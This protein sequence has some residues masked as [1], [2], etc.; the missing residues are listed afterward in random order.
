MPR[1]DDMLAQVKDGQ[2]GHWR[3]RLA[4]AEELMEAFQTG[5]IVECVPPV[6]D[7]LLAFVG[8][9]KWEVRK[10]VA[11][12][13]SL[14][15]GDLFDELAAKL[16]ADSNGFVRGAAERSYALRREHRR[17]AR[18]Q[19]SAEKGLAGR[20]AALRQKYGNDVVNDIFEISDARFNLMAGS[21]AHDMRSIFT[22]L[23]PAAKAML[24]AIDEDTDRTVLKRKADR[25]VEDMSIMEH[26]IADMELFTEPLPVERHPEDLAEVLKVA[27]EMARKNIEELGFDSHMVVLRQQVPDGL[28]LP[29]S[30]HLLILA[31]SNLVKNAY[32]SFMERHKHLRRGEIVIETACGN[33]AVEIV[34]RDTGMGMSSENL[35]EL[36]AMVPHR[37]NKAKRKSTG[38]GVPI[39]HRY[40]EAHGGSI[41]FDSKEDVGTTVTIKLPKVAG[42]EIP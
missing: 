18:R 17:E 27:C 2:A 25:V 15:D 24:A 28:R 20:L 22:H 32:E 4:L 35:A 39:A 21:M 11:N 14:I 42:E 36:T 13:L 29:V 9:Q 37:R 16:A 19:D 3:Q 31:V 30:R 38:F 7:L 26:C 10:T 41:A 40:I 1:W 5:Q 8:D 34:I 6:R 23:Q 12:G 33:D